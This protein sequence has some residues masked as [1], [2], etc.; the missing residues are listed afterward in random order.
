MRRILSAASYGDVFDREWPK[1]KRSFC[2][3][4]K[5]I[6]ASD[7]ELVTLSKSCW[8]K[9]F[10]FAR[11]SDKP[12]KHGI[13]V[14][15]FLGADTVATHFSVGDALEVHRIDELIRGDLVF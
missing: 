10:S 13:E 12:L 15:L 8:K 5:D 4:G 11:A 2:Q 3:C 9:R 6:T 7:R 14:R 1:R